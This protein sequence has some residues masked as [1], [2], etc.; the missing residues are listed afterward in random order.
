MLRKR[1]SE[2][3]T[4]AMAK[5]PGSL[6]YCKHSGGSLLQPKSG[7]RLLAATPAWPARLHLPTLRSLNQNACAISRQAGQAA[8]SSRR[9]ALR[10]G[11]SNLEREN[12]LCLG[13]LLPHTA[14]WTLEVHSEPPRRGGPTCPRAA[15]AVATWPSCR[16]IELWD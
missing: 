14:A 5:V 2:V 4:V 10:H 12:S 9:C 13:Q 16:F 1:S 15:K 11:S 7:L 8:P 6:E 3:R